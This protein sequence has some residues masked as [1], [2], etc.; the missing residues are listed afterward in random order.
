MFCLIVF[1]K[2]LIFYRLSIKNRQLK[3]KLE[4]PQ[5]TAYMQ[6]MYNYIPNAKTQIEELLIDVA[7]FNVF[8]KNY[9]STNEVTKNVA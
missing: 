5:A 7:D 4:N 3:A 8:L 1:I 9:L 2:I 6:I